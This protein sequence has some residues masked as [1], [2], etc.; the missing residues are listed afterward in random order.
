[1]SRPKFLGHTHFTFS[2]PLGKSLLVVA[3]K[4]KSVAMKNNCPLRTFHLSSN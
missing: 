3:L 4:K 1:M 2:M